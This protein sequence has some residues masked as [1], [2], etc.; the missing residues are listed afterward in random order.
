MYHETNLGFGQRFKRTRLEEKSCGPQLVSIDTHSLFWRPVFTGVRQQLC[1]TSA[2]A[3]LPDPSEVPTE[4]R[5]TQL[6]ALQA[7]TQ[8]LKERS[9]SLDDEQIELWFTQYNYT[10]G[11]Y[12][13]HPEKYTG[14]PWPLTT[15]MQNP[16]LLMLRLAYF[17]PNGTI[18][19]ID[20]SKEV[21]ICDDCRIATN[22]E[23][24]GRLLW[25]I[26]A[27]P[28]R[29]DVDAETGKV[30]S[31]TISAGK[32]P[33]RVPIY[34]NVGE[35]KTIKK[36]S[37]AWLN[38]PRTTNIEIIQ[39]PDDSS[40]NSSTFQP[41]RATGIITLSN[42]VVWINND[43]VAHTVRYD[44]RYPIR[45]SD[46]FRSGSIPPGGTYEHTFERVGEYPYH[47]DI[48]PWMKGT[49]RIGENFA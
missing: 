8:T 31:P 37:Q 3:I 36:E 42:K 38:P 32:Y 45:L 7:A 6:Q 18:Y 12:E 29:V 19:Y 16:E 25:R 4:P 46:Q 11:D 17:H 41:A 49:V 44:D 47:C 24:K 40:S 30:I 39:G 10:A 27:I 26:D 15:V 1:C 34:E 35:A 21:S 9:P 23:R 2:S 43:V 22:D 5:I 13:A 33:N 28:D 20:D 48:H 14:Y